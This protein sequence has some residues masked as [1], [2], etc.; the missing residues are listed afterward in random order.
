VEGRLWC[1][2]RLE[3]LAVEDNGRTKIKA[4]SSQETGRN[5]GGNPGPAR[6]NNG[7][8]LSGAQPYES[9]K[10]LV[11]EELAKAKAKG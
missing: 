8:F 11:D 10:R 4:E 6:F 1:L 9:F 2:L 7:R 3:E 5:A